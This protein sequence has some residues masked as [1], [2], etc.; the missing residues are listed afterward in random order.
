MWEAG[1]SRVQPSFGEAETL[2]QVLCSAFHILALRILGHSWFRQSVLACCAHLISSVF[3][4]AICLWMKCSRSGTPTQK[5]RVLCC[6]DFECGG[7]ETRSR[8][9]RVIDASRCH[10]WIHFKTVR[11]C[12]CLPNTVFSYFCFLSKHIPRPFI[13]LQVILSNF[14]WHQLV[15]RRRFMKKSNKYTFSL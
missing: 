1:G 14:F 10:S 8:L 6:L 5:G 11:V 4:F 12:Q 2:W 13:P 15:T 7:V 9:I 3:F